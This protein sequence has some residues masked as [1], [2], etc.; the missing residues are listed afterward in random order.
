M[1]DFVLFNNSADVNSN[2]V[3]ANK[4]GHGEAFKLAMDTFA[5]RNLVH[6]VYVVLRQHIKRK[7]EARTFTNLFGDMPE[8]GE[9]PWIFD[10]K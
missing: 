2:Q 7:R 10:Y 8:L 1:S 4:T 9:N 5:D 3:I 6:H